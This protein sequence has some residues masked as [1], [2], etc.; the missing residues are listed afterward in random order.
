[1]PLVDPQPGRG[2]AKRGQHRLGGVALPGQGPGHHPVDR[3]IRSGQPSPR[4]LRLPPADVR[5]PVIIRRPERR[6]TVPNQ[7]EHTH[8][9][10]PSAYPHPLLAP[11]LRPIA[12][13]LPAASRAA[14]AVSASEVAGRATG[15]WGTPGRWPSD[16]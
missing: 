6:L 11:P 13:S 3:Q 4:D 2:P 1:E 16:S 7:Q 8:T 9:P 5:K 15:A 10:Q 12:P 14:T